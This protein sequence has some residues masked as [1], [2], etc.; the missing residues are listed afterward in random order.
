[1]ATVVGRQFITLYVRLYVQ[2][3]VC[4][5]A[6]R[7]GL[8]AAA[9]T[10]LFAVSGL[11][12]AESPSLRVTDPPELPPATPLALKIQTLLLGSSCCN[13]THYATPSMIE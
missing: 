10:W 3:D 1:M 7:A 11:G 13:Y 2:H 12:V 4:E 8:S 9:E 5:A 6:R